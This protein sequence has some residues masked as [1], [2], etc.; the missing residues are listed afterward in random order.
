MKTL[1]KYLYLPF[2]LLGGNWAALTLIQEANSKAWLVLLVLMLIGISF[3]AE[4]VL[5]Y[6]KAFNDSHGDR[7]RDSIHA[8]VNE[9]LS[10][11]GWMLLPV[12]G[13]VMTVFPVWPEKWGL[14]WQ[15]LL[16]ILIAD[17]GI[18]LTHYASHK[19]AALWHLHAIHHSVTRMY[20]FNGLMKHP[21]HQLI[22]TIA[23]VLPLLLIGIP[24]DVLA[25]LIVAVAIQLLLQHSNT[26][27]ATGPFHT[28]L[29]INKVHRFHHVKRAID[30]DVNFGLFTT[31]TD[32]IL[33]TA[34]YRPDQRF[35]TED[36]GIASSPNFPKRYLQQLRYPFSAKNDQA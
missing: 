28:I 26:D 25:L 14:A 11:F 3:L 27:Y 20:G 4:R 34:Y 18:T 19:I 13:G 8:I 24:S 21:L 7:G 30:G 12:I 23:G 16:A 35:D 15:L 36:L 10:L 5:P 6:N 1:V 17:I 29:A 32:R 33:G 9:S 31:L 2:M 22:E